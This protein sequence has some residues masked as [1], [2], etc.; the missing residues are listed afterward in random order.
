MPQEVADFIFNKAAL[1]VPVRMACALITGMK[2]NLHN[3]TIP[4]R[5]VLRDVYFI[6]AIWR[7]LGEKIVE[8]RRSVETH[9]AFWNAV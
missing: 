7:L 9:L 5:D 2:V 1:P 3:V 4:E 6:A 8:E